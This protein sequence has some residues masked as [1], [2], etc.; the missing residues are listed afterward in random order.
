MLSY[1]G[2]QNQ[3]QN[4]HLRKKK[5]LARKKGKSLSHS[6]WACILLKFGYNLRL[7]IF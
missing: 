5:F 3:T 7:I 1:S 4:N 6:I 2:E